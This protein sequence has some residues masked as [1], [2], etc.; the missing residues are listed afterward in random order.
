MCCL[1]KA[2]FYELC[3]ENYRIYVARRQKRGFEQPE[4]GLAGIFRDYR[5]AFIIKHLQN[6]I[7]KLCGEK[8]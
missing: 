5:I 1:T 8:D 4:G 3:K 6:G 2:K 7:T